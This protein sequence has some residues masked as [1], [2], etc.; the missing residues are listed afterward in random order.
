[1][2]VKYIVSVNE[3]CVPISICC[4]V[5]YKCGD[6]YINNHIIDVDLSTLS[7]VKEDE[8]V[9]YVLYNEEFCTYIVDSRFYE[10]NVDDIKDIYENME[11]VD[12]LCNISN[13]YCGDL[14]SEVIADISESVYVSLSYKYN[15]DLWNIVQK[16]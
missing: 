14:T 16:Y 12:D 3:D 2:L 11:K 4:Q 5:N 9:V 10:F 1:M 7:V 8:F 13:L 15:I 6:S